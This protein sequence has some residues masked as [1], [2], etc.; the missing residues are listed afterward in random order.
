MHRAPRMFRRILPLA[1][2]AAILSSAAAVLADDTGSAPAAPDSA[3]ASPDTQPRNAVGVDLGLLAPVGKL[4]DA[5]GVML[6]GLVKYGYGVTPAVGITGRIGY[7]Y[8][9]STSTKSGGVSY[10][11]GL[12]DVP[13]WVGGRYFISGRCEGFHIGGELGL[14]VLSV[15]SELGNQSNSA[16]R[17]KVG[18]NLLPGYRIGDFDIQAQLSFLDIGHPGDTFAI[19]ATVGYDFARF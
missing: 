13:I 7:L 18:F 1:L 9:F 8:G 5:T 4:G 17:A 10:K 14:N 6:G 12:S 2:S 15:R 11:E 16:T 19:G 3:A